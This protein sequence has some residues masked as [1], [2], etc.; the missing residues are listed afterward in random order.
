MDFIR[1]FPEKEEWKYVTDNIIEKVIP[2]RYMVST[3]GR[4]FNTF[5]QNYLP[6]NIRYDLNTYQ[7]VSLSLIDGTSKNI[8]VHRLVMKTFCPIE[9]DYEMEPNHIDGYKYNNDIWN[10]EWTSHKEN[11]EHAVNSGL[12]SFGEDRDNS[13]LT[14]EQV[15]HICQLISEG[16]SPDEISK[17]MNLDNCN[18]R[19]IVVNIKLG[20]SWKTI[21]ID[22]DFSKAFTKNNFSNEE[23]HK[24]CK[25]FQDNGTNISVSEICNML[26]IDYNAL[27]KVEKNRIVTAIS[28]IR[29]KKTFKSICNLYNY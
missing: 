23:I 18:I 15:H 28:G 4:V 2:N 20:L 1:K 24:I 7:F 13:I 25:Y 19:K 6:K 16:K 14:N 3:Y 27:S 9:N 11:M 29:K 8:G 17:I 5:T 12:Y 21:S 22:Y 10:L 26:N